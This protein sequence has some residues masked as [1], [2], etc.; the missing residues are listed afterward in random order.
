MRPA[1]QIVT[2]HQGHFPSTV[3][4]I[5]QLPGI[6]RYTAGGD[7]LDRLG[8]P[9]TDCGSQHRAVVM[10]DCYKLEKPVADPDSI[11]LLWQ[12]AQWQLDGTTGSSKSSKKRDPGTTNQAVMEL[13]ALICKPVDPLCLIALYRSYAPRRRPA[14]SNAFRRPNPSVNS[15]P[16]HH[17]ALIIKHRDRWLLRHNP[18][19]VEAWLVG[20]PARRCYLNCNCAAQLPPVA[21]TP[22]RH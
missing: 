1:K 19:A 9:G 4:T 21:P 14:C 20:H 22:G 2:D 16:L 17:V 3:E 8:Q 12:F 18:P 11:R 5:I 15:L 7:R 13:G 10:P 6:G